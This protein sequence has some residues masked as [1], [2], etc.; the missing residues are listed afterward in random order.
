[1]CTPITLCNSQTSTLKI[2]GF[3]YKEEEATGEVMGRW[4]RVQGGVLTVRQGGFRQ[5][6]GALSYQITVGL[7]GGSAAKSTCNAGAGSNT[8]PGG[9]RALEQLSTITIGPVL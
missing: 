4:E 2:Q 5:V 3:G 8:S 7:P 6:H 1:M 9:S